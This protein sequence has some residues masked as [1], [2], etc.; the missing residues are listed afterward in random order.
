M[1]IQLILKFISVVTV[2]ILLGSTFIP[3][4]LSKSPEAGND[5]P[6]TESEL[7]F[8]HHS[9]GNHWLDH[10]LRQSLLDK[11]YITAVNDIYY[12]SAIA[13]DANR[14]DSLQPLPGDYTNMDAWIFW[15]NDYLGSLKSYQNPDG[16][17]ANLI[18][19]LERK[20]IT[21]FPQ[22]RPHFNQLKGAGGA[23]AHNRINMFKSCFPNSHLRADDSASGDPFSAGRTIANNQAIFRNA[24]NPGEP[25]THAEQSYYA[26]E[27]VFAQNPDTLFVVVTSPPLH[28]APE[29]ATSDAAAQRARQFNIWLKTEW[30]A[31][32]QAA[33]PGLNNVAVFDYFDVLAYPPDHASHPNRLKTN[34]GGDSGDSHP[35]AAADAAATAAFATAAD[36]FIDQAWAAFSGQVVGAVAQ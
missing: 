24:A 13:P 26:L 29:D 1:A 3:T 18:T 6:P 2:Y 16:L 31:G 5:N 33:Q 10:G 12:G 20:V 23:D 27:D 19:R 22:L 14:P 21:R 7:V 8:L 11:S 28:F 4:V 9:V 17:V 34:F 25:Y 35:N 15:F 36:N 32:Y 30:L